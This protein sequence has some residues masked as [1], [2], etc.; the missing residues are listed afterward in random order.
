MLVVPLEL[1]V[2]IVIDQVLKHVQVFVVDEQKKTKYHFKNIYSIFN[3][4]SFCCFCFVKQKKHIYSKIDVV[5]NKLL[6]HFQVVLVMVGIRD[7]T[8]L[9]AASWSEISSRTVFFSR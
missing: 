9:P 5:R 3:V 2:H 7:G 8:D 1:L 6:I 4:C